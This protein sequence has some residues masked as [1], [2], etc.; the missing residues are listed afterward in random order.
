MRQL[1][2]II[3]CIGTLLTVV[4]A[5]NK[6]INAMR[7]GNLKDESIKDLHII[8]Q[9]DYLR[10]KRATCDLLSGFGWNHS[11]CAIHC[12]LRGNKGGYCNSRVNSEC[13][14]IKA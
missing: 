2:V 7:N 4:A 12:S 5:Y 3:F 8:D 10:T 14:I 13:K 9:P 1:V 11:P 6:H